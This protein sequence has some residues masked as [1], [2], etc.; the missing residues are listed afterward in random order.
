MVPV[1]NKL[2]LKVGQLSR[3]VEIE[4]GDSVKKELDSKHAKGLGPMEVTYTGPGKLQVK[5][6]LFS[7]LP[8]LKDKYGP[9]G[10]VCILVLSHFRF[11]LFIFIDEILIYWTKVKMLPL[12]QAQK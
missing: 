12:F 10:K 4:A 9:Q 7:I 1:N 11:N 2:E 3:A 6:I 8:K 5:N